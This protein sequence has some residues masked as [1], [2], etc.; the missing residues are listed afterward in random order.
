M[1]IA[2]LILDWAAEHYVLA[3][4]AIL[5]FGKLGNIGSTRVTVKVNRKKEGS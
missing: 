1:D 4:F 2:K 3:F 5:A